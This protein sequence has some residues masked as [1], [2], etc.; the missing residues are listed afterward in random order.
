MTHVPGCAPEK[1]LRTTGLTQDEIAQIKAAFEKGGP[2]A[3]ARHVNDPLLRKHVT[4]A[5]TDECVPSIAAF[6]TTG[7][8]KFVLQIAGKTIEEKPKSSVNFSRVII[9]RRIK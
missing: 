6:E 1:G 5:S 3:T 7:M 4:F 2:E 9:S 8:D